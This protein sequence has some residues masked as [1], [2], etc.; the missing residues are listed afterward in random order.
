[1]APS[2]AWRW[3]IFA[4]VLLL[5]SVAEYRAVSIDAAGQLRITSSTN[6]EMLAPKLDGQIAFDAPAISDDHRT[7][8][9]LAQYP[10]PTLGGSAGTPLSARLVLYRED[11]IARTFTTDQ[12]F[13]DWKFRDAGKRVA[14]STGPTHGGASECVL[15]HTGSGKVI[16]RWPVAPG[17]KPPAWAGSLRR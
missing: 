3:G 7:V 6:Q 1:M 17:A 15:R 9:W 8:G 16:A 4:P 5:A 14:Y 10:D 13:W 12:T 11:R 2:I